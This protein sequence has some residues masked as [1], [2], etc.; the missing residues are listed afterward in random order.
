MRNLTHQTKKAPPNT[1]SVLANQTAV[2][3]P[4]M[5]LLPKISSSMKLKALLLLI[6]MGFLQ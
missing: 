1:A 6:L 4:Y 2:T 5:E 3:K